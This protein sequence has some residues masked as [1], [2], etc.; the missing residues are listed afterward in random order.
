MVELLLAASLF[1]AGAQPAP[2]LPPPPTARNPAVSLAWLQGRWRGPGATMGNADEAVLE[3]RSALGGTF[4]EFSYRAGRF[5]GRAFYRR[6]EAGRWTA[7]WFDNRGVSF[8]IEASAD[9]QSLTS[10]WG[11]DETER[12]RTVYSLAADGRLSVYDM[13]RGRDGSW[14][15]FAR[16]VLTRA[17]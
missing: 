15:A 3:V 7:I 12:G 6:V 14:R 13:V 2:P 1:L 4:T 10:D 17:E 9:G 5:E 8:G 11:S 16:H